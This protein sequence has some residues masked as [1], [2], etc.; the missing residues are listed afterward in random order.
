MATDFNVTIK[1][2]AC[3]EYIYSLGTVSQS[4]LPAII[5]KSPYMRRLQAVSYFSDLQDVLQTTYEQHVQGTS[6]IMRY[7]A[8]SVARI[9]S[10]LYEKW[11]LASYALARGTL[12]G[13]YV[14]NNEV[15]KIYDKFRRIFCKYELRLKEVAPLPSLIG[16][17]ATPPYRRPFGTYM[18]RLYMKTLSGI[19][20]DSYTKI[21]TSILQGN[22]NYTIGDNYKRI[23]SY[24]LRALS[25]LVGFYSSVL[26]YDGVVLL[27]DI[28]RALSEADL[29]GLAGQYP[30]RLR[31]I[32]KY[33][34][35]YYISKIREFLLDLVYGLPL[36][37]LNGTLHQRPD[38]MRE[39]HRRY[40]LP[41]SFLL[42]YRVLSVFLGSAYIVRELLAKLNSEVIKSEEVLRELLK[43]LDAMTVNFQ[44]VL[45]LLK[46]VPDNPGR[47]RYLS[48]LGAPSLVLAP[49][50]MSPFLL[51]QGPAARIN[52][53]YSKIMKL[54]ANSSDPQVQ[55]KI[56]KAVDKCVRNG[57][58]CLLVDKRKLSGINTNALPSVYEIIEVELKDEIGQ[59]MLVVPTDSRGYDSV[60]VD[61]G[62]YCCI[63]DVQRNPED[64]DLT[65]NTRCGTPESAIGTGLYLSL[66]PNNVLGPNPPLIPFPTHQ[67]LALVQS[68]MLPSAFQLDLLHRMTKDINIGVRFS[69]LTIDDVVLH[70]EDYSI[71]TVGILSNIYNYIF[72]KYPVHAQRVGLLLRASDEA[73]Y[74]KANGLR[75][76][77]EL[78]ILYY[79][80]LADEFERLASDIEQ[81]LNRLTG[82]GAAINAIKGASKSLAKALRSLAALI[83]S[84]TREVV[85]T[86]TGQTGEPLDDI[87]ACIIDNLRERAGSFRNLIDPNVDHIFHLK[88]IKY[89]WLQAEQGEAQQVEKEYLYSTL[90][91]PGE[92]G[93]ITTGVLRSANV[94]PSPNLVASLVIDTLQT[95]L[96]S[97][98]ENLVKD[99]LEDILR[100]QQVPADIVELFM[101]V[102]TQGTIKTY[103]HLPLGVPGGPR[104]TEALNPKSIINALK[105]QAVPGPCAQFLVPA[106]IRLIYML[107]NAGQGRLHSLDE[108]T[109][110]SLPRVYHYPQ[111]GITHDPALMQQA[112]LTGPIGQTGSYT[113]PAGHGVFPIVYN[114]SLITSVILKP[115]NSRNVHLSLLRNNIKEAIKNALEHII[116]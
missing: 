57:L 51:A 18:K 42:R 87:L 59:S 26:T 29:G 7:Y 19:V 44:S 47:I 78:A 90:M 79:E 92:L 3:H 13:S 27:E 23:L 115:I 106:A 4:R 114:V 11:L 69:N 49:T 68:D 46:E 61:I 72:R 34:T 109:E 43:L 81:E 6:Y 54:V 2:E 40:Q 31:D 56:R 102:P 95:V 116:I 60:Y 12:S 1:D 100:N 80:K 58:H 91:P 82:S 48:G 99:E 37:I 32:E 71:L 9:F 63:L 89:P 38:L 96:S 45:L 52:L 66:L 53:I 36:A 70:I 33:Y 35:R 22:I 67:L 39:A 86:L 17:L 113:W 98:L 105:N 76:I 94:Q 77:D 111:I 107:N 103:F 65:R 14:I 85:A 83:H 84:L 20:W 41:S 28:R 110:G 97:K 88:D 50:A 5:A 24:A 74:C 16:M 30:T 112:S 104:I 75:I 15:Y 25:G 8:P 101:Q 10:N 73:I 108:I 64:V 21:V 93:L 62:T 55:N